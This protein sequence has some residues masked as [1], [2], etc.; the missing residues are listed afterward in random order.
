M[1]DWPQT[2]FV[3]CCL[4]A[5]LQP[6]R[7]RKRVLQ[8][9][10]G[11][12]SPS[13]FQVWGQHKS[14]DSDTDNMM[15]L[16][17]LLLAT[18]LLS[19]ACCGIN[20]DATVR[21]ASSGGGWRSMVTNFGYIHAFEKAGLISATDSAFT[22]A[23]FNSGASWFASQL[24][25]SDNFFNRVIGVEPDDIFDLSTAWLDDYQQYLGTTSTFLCDLLSF[26]PS[27]I[28]ATCNTAFQGSWYEFIQGMLESAATN[29]YDD[30][31]FST[32]VMSSAAR[33]SALGDTNL[34]IQ[35]G[36]SEASRY[37][38]SP[39]FARRN[40]FITTDGAANVLAVPLS[41][42]YTVTSSDTSFRYGIED[43]ESLMTCNAPGQRFFS[44]GDW[45]D[46]YRH[47]A[48]GN[49]DIFSQRSVDTCNL[50]AFTEPFGGEVTVA[51]ATSSSS[52]NLASRSGSVP[53]F[54][55]HHYS[56]GLSDATGF[57]GT[58]LTTIQAV[59]EH[60]FGPFF[61]NAIC[62]Q[63]PLDCG[64]SDGRMIDGGFTDG[65]SK[66]WSFVATCDQLVTD[67]CTSRFGAKY[68][69]PSLCRKRRPDQA[70]QDHFN[71]QQF[72]G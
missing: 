53:T 66:L 42:Q 41:A 67:P 65:P 8:S 4:P 51:Q 29:V 19:P 20:P 33:T 24:F 34:M 39:V 56:V 23:S 37:R 9:K 43:G 59:F 22:A 54:L 52:A 11:G 16:K 5:G 6:A 40:S 31:G 26:L 50:Q 35:T 30:S 28:S 49:T 61:E 2:T 17:T 10:T 62:S 27:G 48:E 12:E 32:R 72:R 13:Q 45:D 25:Y 68:R 58:I 47:P 57:M 64:P 3:R 44:F 63:A 21:W 70:T 69:P 14:E 46:W 7:F 55:F 36:L 60:G 38:A 71:K 1:Y 18:A 15:K